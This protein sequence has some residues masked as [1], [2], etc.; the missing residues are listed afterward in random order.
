MWVR[1]FPIFPRHSQ[2]KQSVE[3]MT[4]NAPKGTLLVQFMMVSLAVA[5]AHNLFFQHLLP[6]T[7]L[8]AESNR[9]AFNDT[10]GSP[11]IH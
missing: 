5:I 2:T 1:R 11:D 10:V 6:L 7:G 4:K 9:A 3:T 8:S